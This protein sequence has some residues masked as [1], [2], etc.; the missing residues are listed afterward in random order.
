MLTQVEPSRCVR[1]RLLAELYVVI[2]LFKLNRI[3]GELV[4][5]ESPFLLNRGYDVW[6]MD[7]RAF[8][9]STRNLSEKAFKED[10]LAGFARIVPRDPEWPLITWGRSFG[11]GVSVAAPIEPV[12][13]IPKP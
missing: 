1:N 2:G 11:I 3:R 10:A 7:Y 12:R 4:I 9:D 5:P 8:G 13:P 6:T